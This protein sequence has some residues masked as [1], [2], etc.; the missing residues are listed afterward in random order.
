MFL[1]HRGQ[2]RRAPWQF[3]RSESVFPPSGCF[4]RVRRRRW[5]GWIICSSLKFASQFLR[6]NRHMRFVQHALMRTGND[7]DGYSPPGQFA[8]AAGIIERTENRMAARAEQG[9]MATERF[10]LMFQIS[11]NMRGPK[12]MPIF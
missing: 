11:A 9:E 8:P 2:G 12:F 6:Q 5:R 10:G 3:I 4:A 1:R 7:V